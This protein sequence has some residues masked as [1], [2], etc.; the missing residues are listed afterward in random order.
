MQYPVILL[1]SSVAMVVVAFVMLFTVGPGGFGVTTVVAGI[2]FFL[3][4]SFGSFEISA[5]QKGIDVDFHE[6]SPSGY[7]KPSV[8]TRLKEVFH[9]SEL[10][11]YEQA[12]AVCAAYDSELASFDQLQEAMSL[13]AEWCSYGWSAGGMGL[14]PTQESTW[15]ALQQ[16]PQEKKRTACGRPGVNGGYFEPTLKFGVNCYGVK[17]KNQGMKFPLPLPND[18]PNFQKDVDKFK[19][20]KP[21][22]L[23]AFNRQ[24]WSER[25]LGDEAT[26]LMEKD[27]LI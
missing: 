4:Y 22:K 14:Y 6:N 3:L 5:G 17:P 24:I 7:A 18:D 23:N 1:W 20:M 8:G 27:L 2:I 9:I 11:N 15:L 19:H 10:V 21:L 12:P 25:K 16:E 13:G 26:S